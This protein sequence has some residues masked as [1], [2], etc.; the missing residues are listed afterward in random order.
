MEGGFQEIYLLY[1]AWND[2]FALDFK[3]AFDDKGETFLVKKQWDE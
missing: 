1:S 3:H 2:P